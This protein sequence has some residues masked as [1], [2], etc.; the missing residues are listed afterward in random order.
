MYGRPYYN[1][2]NIYYMD[3]EAA[4][5]G[6]KFKFGLY[7]D[8]AGISGIFGCC[9]AWNWKGAEFYSVRRKWSNIW[10]GVDGASFS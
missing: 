6:Q 10:L 4:Y 8:F 3:D 5:I 1:T 9:L 2:I 7:D